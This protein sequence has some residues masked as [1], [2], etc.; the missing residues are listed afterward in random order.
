MKNKHSISVIVPAY[1]EEQNVVS[2]L[3]SA[4]DFLEKKMNEKRVS[5]SEVSK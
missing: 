3:K 2:L 4:V 5:V 1:N